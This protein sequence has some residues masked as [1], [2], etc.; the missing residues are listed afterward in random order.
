MATDRD[1]AWHYVVG[2]LTA[3]KVALFA[4]LA[5][6]AGADL[7]ARVGDGQYAEVRVAETPAP[8]TFRAQIRRPRPSLFVVGV[9]PGDETVAWVLPSG[10]FER[11]ASGG[12]LALDEPADEPLRERLAVYRNRWTII[13]N[14]AKFRST[15]NDPVSLQMQLALG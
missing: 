8:N 15:L 3:Q 11:F 13:A 9:V 14:F 10:A 2:E 4:P 6:S 1:T 7:L 12:V 5:S